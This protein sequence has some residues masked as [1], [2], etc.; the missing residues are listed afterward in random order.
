MTVIE[1]LNSFKDIEFQAKRMLK[2]K[3][4]DLDYLSQFDLRCEEIR[5]QI[6]Q[7]D[8]SDEINSSFNKIGRIEVEYKPILNFGDKTSNLLT[9]GLTKKNKINK[10]TDKYYR[11]E[12]LI[13]KITIQHVE[14]HLK[15]N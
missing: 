1:L 2:S 15:E 10:K 3:K 8:L 14:T 5:L 9:F 11:D 7:M 12:I 4:I 6:L 13:R